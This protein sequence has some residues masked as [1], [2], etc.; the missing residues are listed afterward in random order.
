M[1]DNLIE[2]IPP[3]IYYWVREFQH[4]LFAPRKIC[5]YCVDCEYEIEGDEESWWCDLQDNETDW[6]NTCRAFKRGKR[7]DKRGT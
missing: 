2:H 7:I 6:Q 5:L 3:P 4:W 1:L